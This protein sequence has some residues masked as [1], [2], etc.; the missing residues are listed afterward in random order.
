[1]AA[2]ESSRRLNPTDATLWAIKRDPELR[3]TIVGLG[4]LDTTP[5][6]PDVQ[7][8]VAR[9]V[10]R[11]PRLR[12]RVAER[13]LGLG[14]PRWVDVTP[15]PAFHLRRI[16]APEPGDLRAVL[17]LCGAL[18]AEDFDETRPLWQVH[19]VEGLAD[20][21]AAIV[22][23]V[24]HALTDG[25]GGIGLLRLF[26][27]G[28]WNGEED[29]PSARSTTAAAGS[30]PGRTAA[31]RSPAMPSS[32]FSAAVGAGRHPV[33]SASDAIGLA[34]S[35]AR[36]IAPA[37]RPL[38]TLMTERG[39]ARWAGLTELPLERLRR[40]AHRAGGSINDGFVAIAVGAL[41]D[42]HA[43]LGSGA[44]RFRVT[45]PVS[46][47][48]G[49]D[50]VGETDEPSGGNQWTP[51]RLVL[52]VDPT[53]HPFAQLRRHRQVVQRA[54]HEPAISF[55][56]VLAAGMLELPSAV[57]TGI[58]GGMVKG[59]DI[60]LTD[61]PGLTEPL[62]IAGS[63][64]THFFPF[65]PTGGAA[66][67]IGLVSHL[68]IA[69]IGFN[70]DTAA[71]T[72]PERFV[73]CFEARAEDFLRRRRRPT[74]GRP[75]GRA[76]SNGE[77]PTSGDEQHR[78][79]R[80]GG[81]RL[82][83]LDTSFLRM[84]SPT[85]PMHLGGLFVI[86][87]GGL[88]SADDELDIAALRRHV[89]GRLDRV[90]RLR[91]KLQDVPLELGRP[92]WVDDPRFDIANHVHHRTLP[93]P[94]NRVQLLELCEEL[95][96]ELLDRRRPLFDLTFIEGL[97]PTE[98][99]AGAIG[100]VE[101][102]HHALL[103]GMSGVEMVALLF[104]S[105]PDAAGRTVATAD[106]AT[107]EPTPSRLRLIADATADQVGEPLALARLAGR[108]IISPRRT[109][110]ELG[111]VAATIGDLLD[112]SH[113]T[114][115][116]LSRPVGGRR[117]L[118]AISMPLETVHRTGSRLGGSVNDM[119]LTAV[120]CGV[121]ALLDREGVP[122]DGPFTALVPVSTRHRGMDAEHG[123]HV[124]GLLVELP[125]D[126]DEPGAMFGIV[127][128]RMTELKEEHRA[129]GSELLLDAAD[130]LPPL[131]VDLVA[132]A[133]AHQWSVDLVVTNLAGPPTP[134]YLRGSRVREMIPIVPLGPNLPIGVA[135]L[136]YDGQLVVA[137]HATDEIGDGLDLL[138]DATREAFG[139]LEDVA[140]T[141]EVAGA[142]DGIE[143]EVEVEVEVTDPIRQ[144]DEAAAEATS[145]RCMAVP[146][147]S[148]P[149]AGR[150]NSTRATPGSE[151][152]TR[153]PRR[154]SVSR[155]ALFSQSTSATKV[156][157]PRSAATSTRVER[158]WV[159]IPLPCQRSATVTAASALVGSARSRIHR[160]T[161]IPWRSGSSR[162]WAPKAT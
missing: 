39:T 67:N 10:E 105:D 101:R 33:N 54:I 82:S 37:G 80:H 151:D 99:G 41:A 93:V 104:D 57:T 110:S 21:R 66:L 132:R 11:L 12:Q 81:E 77:P 45:L 69:C 60:A 115:R 47:R 31:G 106:R 137:F 36:L 13:P 14:R 29:N 90:P 109:V 74:D 56:Q 129:D 100:L 3:T 40:A 73:R 156:V 43:E 25:I 2:S 28:A 24:S 1:M 112:P 75:A 53:S 114:A 146:S 118:R 148:T 130:H 128:D 63:E 7:A 86:D 84:E 88:P 46:Q 139:H 159:P 120:S 19:L 122:L 131:A 107:V 123:N 141:G 78:S 49:A 140:A 79:E 133:I 9:A 161:P 83:A 42:Y 108:A 94:G 27:D 35:A 113:L 98:F 51:A 23:K 150:S 126:R 119:V 87:G 76:P 149:G 143:V 145:I 15:D 32:I 117:R 17:D 158:S 30:S 89:E 34:G 5:A 50:Q 4:L 157:M 147:S 121:R 16:A 58:V 52:E 6:W 152:S 153:A 20:D 8:A 44:R 61:V 85:A 111:R 125:V 55:G 124:A 144:D 71:V 116:P 142:G 18:A 103:D 162:S 96:M 48:S 97:D 72:E 138:A 68:G 102:V 154:R 155:N 135:V 136:S 38:S 64:L 62:P 95:Q 134:L 22:I 92:L 70:I 59:S 91:R 127:S 65:A 26:G 160:A